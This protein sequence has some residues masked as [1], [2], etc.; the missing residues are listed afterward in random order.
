MHTAT[1]PIPFA[2]RS[3]RRLALPNGVELHCVEQGQGTR[4]PP[5]FVAESAVDVEHGEPEAHAVRV[6]RPCRSGGRPVRSR[7]IP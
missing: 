5:P 6:A 3:P 7:G 1:L 4:L 2:Q